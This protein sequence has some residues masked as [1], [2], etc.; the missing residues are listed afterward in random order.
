MDDHA[1]KVDIRWGLTP[2]K[3][4]WQESLP[5]E[6]HQTWDSLILKN[7]K[8]WFITDG[9]GLANTLN[10][11][12]G[13][14]H[15]TLHPKLCLPTPVFWAQK[16]HGFYPRSSSKPTPYPSQDEAV[17]VTPDGTPGHKMSGN[18]AKRDGAWRMGSQWMVQWLTTMVIVSPLNGVIP[19]INGPNGLIWEHFDGGDCLEPAQDFEKKHEILIF[20]TCWGLSSH[21]FL[22]IG[23]VI[24]PI[25]GVKIPIIRIPH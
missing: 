18:Q 5:I 14:L 21:C 7:V 1:K 19:L 12:V 4:K 13:T 3:Y 16:P 10:Q 23:M 11:L 9:N 15:R 22:M 24:N 6:F 25:V 17:A 2:Q 8:I 20:N